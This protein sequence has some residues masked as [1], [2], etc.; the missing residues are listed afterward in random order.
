MRVLHNTLLWIGVFFLVVLMASPVYLAY[1]FSWLAWTH[2]SPDYG[3]SN[4]AGVLGLI[5]G[6][7]IDVATAIVLI[8]G[9]PAPMEP[10]QEV[11]P[12]PVSFKD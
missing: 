6:I 4:A 8:C 1:S 7:G 9:R 11:I 2:I 10:V 12:K 5:I 3:T